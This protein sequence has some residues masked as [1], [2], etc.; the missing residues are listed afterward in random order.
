MIGTSG[1]ET[2]LNR[3]LINDNRTNRKLR[4]REKDVMLE[5][6]AILVRHGTVLR[7]MESISA[8]RRSVNDIASASKLRSTTG[9]AA[10]R[11]IL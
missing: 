7:Q 4:Q 6:A 2:H 8:S 3:S 11:H 5:G 1:T 9:T 10:S